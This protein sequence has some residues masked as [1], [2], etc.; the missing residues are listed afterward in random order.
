MSTYRQIKQQIAE[1]EKKADAARRAE[2]A[3]VIASIRAQ[4]AKFDLKSEDI[5]DAEPA[6]LPAPMP[7]ASKVRPIK[8]SKPPKYRDPA[9]GKTWTGHGKPPG[10]LA[11]ATKRG[12]RDDYL[13]TKPAPANDPVPEENMPASAA[14]AKAVKLS[15]APKSSSAAKTKPQVATKKKS[16]TSQLKKS[17]VTKKSVA[18]PKIVT[19]TTSPTPATA[20]GST[21][22]EE[23]PPS[24]ET[25]QA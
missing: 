2:A 15:A 23:A 5:F 17:S 20:S 14:K 16:G 1:L 6:A 25:T 22:A 18:K 21:D 11:E 7:S 4:V 8:K 9:S 13:I 10:W 24:V 3:K 19:P 12:K